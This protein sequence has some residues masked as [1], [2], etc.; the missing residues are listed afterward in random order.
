MLYSPDLHE[1][2]TDRTWDEARVR[3]EIGAID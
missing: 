1:A 2:L 3:D